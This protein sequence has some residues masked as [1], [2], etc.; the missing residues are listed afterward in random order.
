MIIVMGMVIEICGTLFTQ[1]RICA[2][3]FTFDESVRLVGGR[4]RK[5]DGDWGASG[6]AR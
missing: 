6:Q 2:T 4:R 5:E 1:N 3:C